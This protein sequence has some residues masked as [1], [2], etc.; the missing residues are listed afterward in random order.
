MNAGR[1]WRLLPLC[2]GD[3]A[4]NM[5]VDEAIFRAYAEGRVP[6]TLR[7]YTWAPPAVSCGRFQD[8]A[9]EVDLDALRRL[10][11]GIV[12]RP[13]GGRAVLHHGDLTYAAVIGDRDGLPAGTLPAYL[14][15][16]QG[17]LAGLTGLGI[18]A[19]LHSPT[20]KAAGGNPACFASPSWHELTVAGRKVAGSAQRRDA[21]V[22]LQH[23]SILIDFAPAALAA[24]LRPRGFIPNYAARLAGAAAGLREFAPGLTQ[25]G[26][27]AAIT[28]GFAKA[29]GIS[30]VEG[31]L[32][33]EEEK[34]SEELRP[35]YAG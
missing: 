27:A 9:G 11:F 35:K 32:T 21:G 28:A 24:V 29:L 6:P 10:G 26:L 2:T 30:F 33:E 13:T 34:L 5:A 23:G 18:E 4:R 25:A 14:Y 16:S 8:M 22:V 12:R 19:S 7:F 20:G 3:A 1:A 31:R 15:I 17:L